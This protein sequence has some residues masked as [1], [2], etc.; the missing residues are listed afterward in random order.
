MSNRNEL[1][2]FQHEVHVRFRDIDAGG[3]AHHSLALIYFEE[4]RAAY[5]RKVAGRRT[6]HEID[7]ILAEATV[8]YHKRVFWP[9]TLT[10]GVRVSQLGKKHFVMEYEAGSADGEPVL[11]GRTVQVMYDYGTARTK[12]IPNPLRQRIERF[13]QLGAPHLREANAPT[14]PRNTDEPR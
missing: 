11:S 9:G 4:A 3:H 13:E 6:L 12:R 7:Y 2:R 10:V 14:T 5:W 1:F 8:R